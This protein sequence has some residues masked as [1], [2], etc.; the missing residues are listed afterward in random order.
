MDPKEIK[1]IYNTIEKIRKNS[2]RRTEDG[3]K[4]DRISIIFFVFS[5]S[6]FIISGIA[7]FIS[8]YYKLD[9]FTTIF[10]SIFMIS[11]LF[12]FAWPFMEIYLRRKV[13]LAFFKNSEFYMHTDVMK[14]SIEELAYID[15]LKQQSIESLSFVKIQ[16]KHDISSRLGRTNLLLGFVEKT[17]LLPSILGLVI[18]YGKIGEDYEFA[19]AIAIA[20]PFLHILAMSFHVYA[21]KV[22]K[23]IDLID[24]IIDKKK[25]NVK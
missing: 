9:N 1:T 16:L 25:E 24:F 5:I 7:T 13:I 18:A 8:S 17:G 22:N 23:I 21:S 4:S 11:Y 14:L 6:I 2:T 3:K 19:K 20:I 15:Q 10:L 12:I